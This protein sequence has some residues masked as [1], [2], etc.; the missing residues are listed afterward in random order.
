MIGGVCGE[1]AQHQFGIATDPGIAID[2][3]PLA[4]PAMV[5]VKLSDICLPIEADAARR[6]SI[7]RTTL[8]LEGQPPKS[9]EARDA[10]EQ[11]LDRQRRQQHA[12]DAADHGEPVMPRRRWM[13]MATSIDR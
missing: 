11:E 2:F 5:T 8:A 3:Q 10:I 7:R 12:D 9:P 13:G 1:Q 4:G 6:L